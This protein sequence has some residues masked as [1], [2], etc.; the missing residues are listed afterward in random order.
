MNID[1]IRPSILEKIND[2]VRQ[3]YKLG[4]YQEDVR[5]IYS[6]I[7]EPLIK[8]EIY[9][10]YPND[11]LF[12][13]NSLLTITYYLGAKVGNEHYNNEIVVYDKQHACIYDHFKIKI[14]IDD[15]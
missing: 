5:I 7:I 13:K 9:D 2:A 1:T 4:S 8:R 12:S 11:S 6:P 15:K 3:L 10:T 14:K